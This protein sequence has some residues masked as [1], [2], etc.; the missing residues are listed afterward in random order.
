MIIN[1]IKTHP[2]T[3]SDTNIEAILD[4]YLTDFGE[5]DILAVTSKI[6]WI[7]EGNLIPI[8]TIDKYELI[9]KECDEYLDVENPYNVILTIKNGHLIASSGIDESNG[10]GNF[11]LWPKN[12]E[13]SAK[14]I[15]NYLRNRFWV[16]ECWVIITDSVTRPLKWGVTGIS[17]ASYGFKSLRDYRHTPDIFGRHLHYTQSN[18]ADGLAAST[19]LV[20][21]EGNECT[22]LALIRDYSDI[23]FSD[24]PP[25]QK[26]SRQE[27]IYGALLENPSW[28]KWG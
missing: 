13:I 19:V 15:W 7:T 6:L 2:I 10:D 9:R 20:M 21:G 14:N 12:P 26:I 23:A 22:P 25:D 27:D 4:Q 3:S 16:K 18:I 24:N 8:D 11:I 17:I 28:R 5:K 1:S